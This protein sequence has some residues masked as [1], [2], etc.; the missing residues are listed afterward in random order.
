MAN[1]HRPNLGPDNSG[2]FRPT[3]TISEATISPTPRPV[4][5][6]PTNAAAA[7]VAIAVPAM[8]QAAEA[9]EAA[10]FTAAEGSEFIAGL[11]ALGAI[12]GT[13]IVLGAVFVPSPNSVSTEGKVPGDP[14]LRYSLDNA[15]GI[16]RLTQQSA[17]GSEL[18]ALAHRGRDGIFFE[19][20]TGIPIAR[21]VGGSIV[22][23]AATLADVAEDDTR[24]QSRAVAP[25]RA[26]A[27]AEKPSTLP[28]SRPG[29]AAWSVSQS[30][31]LSSANQS[32]E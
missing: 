25:A 11:A 12:I 9:T 28:R 16:L 30:N 2:A 7:M 21:T 6:G 27:E 19:A 14:D 22:F 31:R 1:G 13:G 17:A 4:S 26:I 10:I 23:D 18:I 20:D 32:S 29:C 3:V 8:E 5:T 24:T 15:A